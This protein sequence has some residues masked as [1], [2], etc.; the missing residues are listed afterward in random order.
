MYTS[1]HCLF[2]AHGLMPGGEVWS[3]GLRT[4]GVPTSGQPSLDALTQV[5]A[6]K[7]KNFFSAIATQ[8]IP[9]S[10]TL[11]GV[12]GRM[13]DTA[14][15]T[16][17]QSEMI[18]TGGAGSGTSAPTLPNQCAVCVTLMTAQGGRS[19]KGRVFLPLIKISM[20]TANRIPLP[21]N[22]SAAFK[23]M[24]DTTHTAWVPLMEGSGTMRYAVQSQK[25]GIGGHP[26]TSIRIGDVVDTQRRRRDSQTEQYT[27][28][29]IAA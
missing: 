9:S 29:N 22:I 17:L 28:A 19:G 24:I 6:D 18:P 2:S 26:I 11:E 5:A 21:G 23:T 12:T 3:C 15:V 1:A 16:L 8:C 20:S 27:A 4:I 25:P 14:G 10:V 13:L 7:W